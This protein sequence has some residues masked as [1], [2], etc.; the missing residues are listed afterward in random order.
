VKT[1]ATWL[2]KTDLAL[3]CISG[4]NPCDMVAENGYCMV[5]ENRSYIAARELT[6][7]AAADPRVA[8]EMMIGYGIGRGR[9]Q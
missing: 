1:H 3:S 6:P 8:V 5:A 4:E 9:G 7:L 2:P